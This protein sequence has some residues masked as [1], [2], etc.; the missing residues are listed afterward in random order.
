MNRAGM[1]QQWTPIC[2][3]APWLPAGCHDNIHTWASALLYLSIQG[4]AKASDSR[5]SNK[6]GFPRILSNA[7]TVKPLCPQGSGVVHLIHV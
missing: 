5:G 6:H 3:Y 2:V 4:N 7:N 1:K